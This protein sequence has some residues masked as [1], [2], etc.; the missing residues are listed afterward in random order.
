M[1]IKKE[2]AQIKVKKDKYYFSFESLPYWK[3]KDVYGGYLE[4]ITSKET[5]SIT[6][7]VPAK[8]RLCFEG[9]DT[10]DMFDE[11]DIE[12][13]YLDKLPEDNNQEAIIK[14]KL[15][16][17]AKKIYQQRQGKVNTDTYQIEFSDVYITENGKYVQ[18]I[19]ENYLPLKISLKKGG[20]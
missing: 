6:D 12:E 5:I 7:E 4:D 2:K 10:Y 1:D 19:L 8:Y 15:K 17:V 3:D 18:S 11:S 13:I 20:N 14:S 16:E 9:E